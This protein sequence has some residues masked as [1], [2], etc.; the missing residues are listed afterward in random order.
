MFPNDPEAQK[1]WFDY[2]AKPD[3]GAREAGGISMTEFRK[4][5][6]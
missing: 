3:L 1:K 4:K 5:L 6:E 2:F